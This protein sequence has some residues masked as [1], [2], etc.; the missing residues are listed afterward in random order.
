MSRRPGSSPIHKAWQ[1]PAHAYR[2]VLKSGHSRESSARPDHAAH[3][4]RW[5]AHEDKVDRLHSRSRQDPRARVR[6]NLEQMTAL[7]SRA[8]LTRLVGGIEGGHRAG[9]T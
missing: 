3:T 7:G 9:R 2:P 6:R 4:S 5:K 1:P 8:W